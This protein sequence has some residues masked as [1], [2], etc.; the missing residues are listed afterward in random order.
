MVGEHGREILREAGYTDDEI[1]ALAVEGALIDPEM[2][3]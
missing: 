3:S 2:E 1:G